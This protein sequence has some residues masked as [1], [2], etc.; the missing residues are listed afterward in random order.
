MNEEGQRLTGAAMRK[1][2]AKARKAAA[3]TATK[4]EALDLAAAIKACQF[5]DLRAKAGT[6][7]AESAGDVRQAQKQLGHAL[8]VMTEAYIRARRGELVRPTR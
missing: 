1:R 7:K 2:F 5:R 4:N 6:D 3:A 8:V